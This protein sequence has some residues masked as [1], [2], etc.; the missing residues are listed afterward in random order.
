MNILDRVNQ[1]HEFLAKLYEAVGA[2]S[3]RY[4]EAES[5]GFAESDLKLILQYAE[6][7][8]WIESVEPSTATN[9]AVIRITH[10]GVKVVEENYLYSLSSEGCD[11]TCNCGNA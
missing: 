3:S 9:Y 5:L 4:V 10:E 11:S 6:N 2:D 8:H 1:R 7:E